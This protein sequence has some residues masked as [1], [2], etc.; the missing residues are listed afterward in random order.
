[1]A[2]FGQSPNLPF[3]HKEAKA[4][5]IGLS[6]RKVYGLQKNEQTTLAVALSADAGACE[7]S[8]QQTAEESD[9]GLGDARQCDCH[10]KIEDPFVVDAHQAVFGLDQAGVSYH[11]LSQCETVDFGGAAPKPAQ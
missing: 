7:C 10:R 6:G 11:Q 3:G 1:M 9:E 5:G 4:P 8:G 2:R